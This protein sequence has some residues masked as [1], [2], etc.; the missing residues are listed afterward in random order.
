MAIRPSA[1]ERTYIICGPES[2]LDSQTQGQKG[3]KIKSSMLPDA[4]VVLTN[5]YGAN[6]FAAIGSYFYSQDQ[7]HAA[8]LKCV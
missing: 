3:Y 6:I 4:Q 5:N 7:R 1:H 8:A 2:M